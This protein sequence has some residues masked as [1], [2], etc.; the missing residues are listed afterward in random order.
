MASERAVEDV[1]IEHLS[2]S[3]PVAVA[4]VRNVKQF[5]R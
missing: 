1:D 2:L 4:T 3:D 5:A